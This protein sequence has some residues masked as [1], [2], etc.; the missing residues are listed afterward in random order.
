MFFA[1]LLTS[2]KK[3]QDK[4][5]N[6]YYV[7]EGD[8]I[9]HLFE[10]NDSLLTAKIRVNSNINRTDSIFNKLYDCFELQE[11]TTSIYT[12]I[13][14]KEE[15]SC[16]LILDGQSNMI[17]L[18]DLQLSG[19]GV[20]RTKYK[21]ENESMLHKITQDFN[22]SRAKFFL[23]STYTRPTSFD[24][25]AS[26]TS[27][28]ISFFDRPLD[29]DTV[30]IL[31]YLT[32]TFEHMLY[33]LR[34]E[35]RNI[36]LC[37]EE[38]VFEYALMMRDMGDFA[39]RV[40]NNP[41]SQKAA[42]QVLDSLNCHQKYCFLWLRAQYE[43]IL[44]KELKN[45]KVTDVNIDPFEDD[46]ELYLSSPRFVSEDNCIK[47]LTKRDNII[48]FLGIKSVRF[49]WSM[50]AYL[51]HVYPIRPQKQIHEDSYIGWLKSMKRTR[52]AEEILNDINEIYPIF[53]YFD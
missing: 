45:Y 24:Y 48:R 39:K 27:N 1:C 38:D 44:F 21:I 22:L 32:K 11:F 14:D 23:D 36:Y 15:G 9:A 53:W 6:P 40:R 35:N 30:R 50:R 47:V 33:A 41:S 13:K 18:L 20:V 4:T 34:Y 5:I 31:K 46:P 26:C 17:A 10:R 19:N 25:Y 28:N 49:N 43:E 7:V 42:M 29:C 52:S 37:T 8:T 2:C 16:K 3:S 12:P 51:D